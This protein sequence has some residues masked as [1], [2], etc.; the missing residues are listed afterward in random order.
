MAAIGGTPGSSRPA[1]GTSP[2]PGAK[3]ED[4]GRESELLRGFVELGADSR[5]PSLA[6]TEPKWKFRF[7]EPMR[8]AL[9]HAVELDEEMSVLIAEKQ[10]VAFFPRR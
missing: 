1:D 3:D 6:A 2:G 4:D 9:L 7:T 10:C 8:M 5:L